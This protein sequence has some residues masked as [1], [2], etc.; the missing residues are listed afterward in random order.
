MATEV[1][2]RHIPT[3]RLPRTGDESPNPLGCRHLP[4]GLV[5]RRFAGT[6]PIELW[7]M[8]MADYFTRDGKAYCCAFWSASHT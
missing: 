1:S 6:R 2:R 5:N 4:A 3:A 8:G 7:C